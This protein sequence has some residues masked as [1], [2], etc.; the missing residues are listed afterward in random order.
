MAERVEI[1]I[2]AEFA[3]DAHEQ[4]AVER[5]GHSQRIVV[6]EDQ[7]SFRLDEIGAEQQQVARPQRAANLAQE[8]ERR[9]R[10]EVAD[11]RSEQENEHGP[12]AFARCRRSAQTLLVGGSMT[13]HRE[14]LEP[15]QTLLRLLERL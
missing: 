5:G 15:G 4:V 2:S 10:I 3:I 14:M 6:R 11:V 12:A 13:D 9:R 1:E 8:L 7:V